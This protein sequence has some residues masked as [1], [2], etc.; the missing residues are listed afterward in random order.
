MCGIVGIVG[1]KNAK[2]FVIESL[3]KLEYRGYDSWGIGLVENGGLKIVKKAGKIGNVRSQSISSKAKI[4]IGHTRWATHGVVTSAN[5]HP[6]TDCK[7]KIAVAHNGIINNYR[8]LREQ[9]Q[10]VG[11][12]FKS[13]TD[14]EVIPHLVEENLKSKMTLREA[15]RKALHQLK[16]DYALCLVSAQENKI[17]LASC[18]CPLTIGINSQEKYISSDIAAFAERTQEVIFLKDNSFAEVGKEIKIFDIETGKAKRVNTQKIALESQKANLGHFKHFLFKEINE[19]PEILEKVSQMATREIETN[20]ALIRNSFGTFFVACGT[21]YH[22]ALA[23]QYFFAKFAKTHVNTALAS[24]FPAFKNFITDK[25]LLFAISQSGETADTLTS[26]RFAKESGADI[27]TMVNVVGSSLT[28][29]VADGERGNN[30][31]LNCGPEICVVATKS[32]LTKLYRLVEIYEIIAEK[33]DKKKLITTGILEKLPNMVQETVD[34]YLD[35]SELADAIDILANSRAVVYIGSRDSFPIAQ[36]GGLKLKETAYIPSTECP[37]SEM[38]HGPIALFDPKNPSSVP[39]VAVMSYKDDKTYSTMESNIREA[40]AR[41]AKVLSV[42]KYNDETLRN[43]SDVY[44]GVPDVPAPYIN[45]LSLI[46]LQLLGYHVAVRNG[47]DVDQPRN[48][49]KSV[50]VE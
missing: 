24:E 33:T 49:A 22:A 40:K 14:T 20:A 26:T 37:A 3:K 43:L 29:V 46:P 41:N 17:Y 10:R 19:Q 39:L 42:G 11:H 1:E 4:A 16:G 8:E 9:L 44:M 28:R 15:F 21:A 32:F 31:Y 27:Y 35:G 30:I 6:H 47:C 2:D 23:A 25:T 12:R 48:L 13:E 38:K 45:L 5:A 36:E 7:A 50:T 18:G 34:R